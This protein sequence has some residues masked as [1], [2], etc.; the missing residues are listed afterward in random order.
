MAKAGTEQVIDALLAT[1]R[2]NIGGAITTLGLDAVGDGYDIADP[3]SAAFGFGLP[4]VDPELDEVF[5]F[6]VDAEDTEPWSTGAI[7]PVKDIHGCVIAI[8]IRDK[9]GDSEGALRKTLRYREAVRYTLSETPHL[10]LGAGDIVTK[11]TTSY[12]Q[13]PHTPFHYLSFL[14]VDF[15]REETWA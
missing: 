9:A 14:R 13:L 7:T 12:G 4:A 3:G 11:L 6:Y 2:D 15:E 1:V 8:S 5:Y 10:G